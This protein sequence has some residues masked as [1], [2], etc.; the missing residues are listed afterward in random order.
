MVL[1]PFLLGHARAAGSSGRLARLRA[2]AGPLFFI[3]LGAALP[4]ACVGS[5]IAAKGAMP[6]MV[7]TLFRFVPSY[8]KL[9][10]RK[11]DALA[12][13]T[14][15]WTE[16]LFGFSRH[17][18]FG[19]LFALSLPILAARERLGLL[20][21]LAVAFFPIIG[22]ALQ[23]K[24]FPYHYAAIVLLLGLPAGWGLWKLWTRLRTHLLPV[25]ALVGVLLLLKDERILPPYRASF[26]ARNR[27]RSQ[28]VFA[29]AERRQ[30]LMDRLHSA[31]NVSAG[32][33]RR[34]ASWIV[35]NT[36]PDQP[37]YV[38]GFEPVIYDL[39]GRASST[40]YIYD[41]PQRVAWGGRYRPR[42]MADL[43]SHPPSVVVVEENDVFPFVTGDR[44][45]SAQSLTG[46]PELHQFLLAHY[47]PGVGIGKLKLFVRR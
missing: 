20:H 24:F 39:A 45:D 10:Y 11:H 23:A 21:V 47:L 8:T 5:Y 31:S 14:R 18:A 7:D 29:N 4:L 35:R 19:I 40:P 30:D 28:S 34:I 16:S 37:I 13:F 6:A 46:F 15:A 1:T 42:L 36:P 2:S 41:V 26:W 3:A 44:L 22:V 25:L 43:T 17:D 9:G 38:W 32:D 33:N 12:L 27:V